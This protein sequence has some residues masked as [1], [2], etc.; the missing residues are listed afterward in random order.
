MLAELTLTLT[1]AQETAVSIVPTSGP[2][3]VVVTR[4]DEL[5]SKAP[6]S[7]T[8]P[9]SSPAGPRT[10][11]RWSVVGIV[12]PL[13]E[14]IPAS[15]AGL[16][17][18]RAMVSVGPAIIGQAAGQA[19]RADPRE[20]C[21]CCPLTRLPAPPVPIRLLALTGEMVPVPDSRDVAGRGGDQV[22][23]FGDDRVVER[24]DRRRC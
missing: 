7:G 9:A 20:S 23:V 22:G 1:L 21:R 13:I 4:Y 16:P 15:M 6:I 11:P 17:A 18:S 5:S 19:R 14:A 24:V 3:A 12:W 2:P 8:V 10:A